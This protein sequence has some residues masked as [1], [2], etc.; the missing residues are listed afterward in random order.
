MIVAHA[1]IGFP[2]GFTAPAAR[3]SCYAR[4]LKA[5]GK[6]VLVLCLGTSEP[7]PPEPALNLAVRG[8]APGGI[9]FEYTCGSTIRSTSFWRRRRS[10]VDGL[11]GAIR[12]IQ[13][14][15]A[16]Q[17]IEAILLFSP[18][19]LDAVAMHVVGRRVGAVCMAEVCEMPFH[20]QKNSLL[21]RLRRTVYNRTFFRWFDAA[22]AISS[23]LERHVVRYG[24]R[25]IGV[26]RAPVMVDTEAFSPAAQTAAG[27]PTVM[28]CG[29]LNQEKDGVMSLMRAVS[30][31]AR[32]IPDVRL[33]LVGDTYHG[34]RI[35]EFRAAAERLGVESR[36]EFVGNVK[37]SDVPA[38][39]AGASVLA[40]ARPS[41][42][43]ADAGMP[44]KVAEYLASG[45]PMVVTQTGDIV[46][47]LED[48]VSAYL[49]PPDDVPALEA[50]LR[51]VL[52]NPA[53]AQ[54]VGRG[55]REVAM[56]HFDQRVV[57]AR[58]AAFIDG[59]RSNEGASAV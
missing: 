5:A 34:T 20:A 26:V 25:E 39:L 41:S 2:N 16:A 58:I 45:V 38:Y 23:P 29:L 22:I 19:S 24:T 35:P 7:S 10:R 46:E 49:V 27:P 50:A 36:I 14:H 52:L 15:H 43:Q 59:L 4:G 33:V 53:E 56:R 44:T 8:T 51:R 13:R 48:G 28:Y 12:S 57:G 37:R 6:D 17:P 18:W 9:P 1:G 11:L 54:A 21:W 42:P 30:G 55:G 3:V 40:L 31:V 32:D 47:Y